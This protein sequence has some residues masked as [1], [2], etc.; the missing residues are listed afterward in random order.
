MGLLMLR[1]NHKD[2]EY[3]ERGECWICQ[4]YQ[5]NDGGYPKLY[6]KTRQFLLHRFVYAQTNSISLGSIQGMVVRHTCDTPE[7]VNPTHLVLG[8]QLD[9]IA[10]MLQKGRNQR[11][12]GNGMSKLTEG[13]V[14]FIRESELSGMALS[15]MFGVKQSCISKVRNRVS[16]KSV[17]SK[18]EVA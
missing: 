13:D 17:M 6:H 3:V 5:L 11:G 7:C 1:G 2:I 9:N 18:V 4:N 14:L 15:K 10:D 16:W 12:E 8:T